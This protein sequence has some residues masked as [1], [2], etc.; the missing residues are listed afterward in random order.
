MVAYTILLEISCRGSFLVI[1]TYSL[2]RNRLLFNANNLVFLYLQAI[3]QSFMYFQTTEGKSS[4]LTDNDF[5]P[6]G[7]ILFLSIR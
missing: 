4:V 5:L 7:G 2:A 3:T 1:L 6:S